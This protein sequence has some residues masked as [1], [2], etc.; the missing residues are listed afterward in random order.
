MSSED[1][2]IEQNID[3]DPQVRSTPSPSNNRPSPSQASPSFNE[4]RNLNKNREIDPEKTYDMGSYLNPGQV[5]SV[6]PFGVANVFLDVV[7]VGLPL[8]FASYCVWNDGRE[9]MDGSWMVSRV[10]L[11]LLFCHAEILDKLTQDMHIQ[12]NMWQNL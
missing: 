10:E 3:I 5:C 8:S 1:A 11:L 2:E 7:W 9:M 6:L 12:D 4:T